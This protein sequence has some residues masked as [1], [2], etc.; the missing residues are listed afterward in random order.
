MNRDLQ[1]DLQK[2]WDELKEREDRQ[3]KRKEIEKKRRVKTNQS[4]E[5]QGFLQPRQLMPTQNKKIWS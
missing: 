4:K 2:Q 5:G 1:E 3:C